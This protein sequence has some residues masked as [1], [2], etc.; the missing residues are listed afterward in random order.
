[1]NNQ[2][3]P[4]PP[5][6]QSNRGGYQSRGSFRGGNQRSNQGGR[7]RGG[8]RGGFK[9]QP[10]GQ[11]HQ[12]YGQ[13]KNQGYQAPT[14]IDYQQATSQQGNQGNFQQNQNYQQNQGYQQPAQQTTGFVSFGNQGNQAQ[15]TGQ[16]PVNP[17]VNQLANQVSHLI[18]I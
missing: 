4:P 14:Q 15:P 3:P 17:Q 7:G 12:Q 1:M 13:S 8:N 5:T 6:G 16:T 9:N 2:P 10:Y 18:E 11:N